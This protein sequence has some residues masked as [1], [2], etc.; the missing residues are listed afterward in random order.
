MNRT[1]I[2]YTLRWH[3]DKFDMPH[4]KFYTVYGRFHCNCFHI[5]RN[6]NDNQNLALKN[7]EYYYLGIN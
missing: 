4:Q 3:D 6:L 2:K 1:T 7:R 5:G